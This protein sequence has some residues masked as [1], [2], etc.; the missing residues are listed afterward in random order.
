MKKTLVLWLFLSS[1]VVFA[2]CVD[3]D[4]VGDGWGMDGTKKCR[5]RRHRVQKTVPKNLQIISVDVLD[6]SAG[7]A[8]IE[9][10]FSEPA[11]VMFKY[12]KTRDLERSGSYRGFMLLETYEQSL[13][14]LDPD[15]EYFYKLVVSDRYRKNKVESN[16][17]S[18]KTLP[19]LISSTTTIS[20]TTTTSSS[21]TTTSTTT[22]LVS[23][24]LQLE[25]P[26]SNYVLRDPK[27]LTVYFSDQD[28]TGERIYDGWI[29]G[30]DTKSEIGNRA[31][32]VTVSDVKNYVSGN[33]GTF[34]FELRTLD[35]RNGKLPSFSNP[36]RITNNTESYGK[37]HYYSTM[38]AFNADSSKIAL[39][40]G[41]EGQ[42]LGD[43]QVLVDLDGRELGVLPFNRNVRWSRTDPDIV[44]G[45]RNLKGERHTGDHDLIRHNIATGDIKVI[46]KSSDFFM[47]GPKSSI[48]YDEK[49]I[50]IRTRAGD[51]KLRSLNL[52]TGAELGSKPDNLPDNQVV[53]ITPSGK[54][55]LVVEVDGNSN[56][57]Y[58]YNRDFTNRTFLTSNQ[59]HADVGL[60]HTGTRDILVVLGN[61]EIIDI[62]SG[63]I[64]KPDNNG[65]PIYGHVSGYGMPGQFLISGKFNGDRMLF[66]INTADGVDAIKKRIKWGDLRDPNP[67]SFR[68][69]QKPNLSP[70]GLRAIFT[71]DNGTS[72][73]DE[74]IIQKSYVE[75]TPQGS[76]QIKYE[77]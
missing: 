26:P 35:R 41:P 30:V 66:E 62:E 31:N 53:L 57:F 11:R 13:T 5:L 50:S 38:T 46:Y 49:F 14:N 73:H 54:Y 75:D 72:L 1:S 55:I 71:E 6:I 76:C 21:S 3:V 58:R 68:S 4:P 52:D 43:K 32:S 77:F 74:Y 45:I 16:I 36:K 27:N 64:I 60:D 7:S 34:T 19:D 20:T 59:N 8:R 69:M 9:A 25:C 37:R 29:N 70:D 15:T 39:Q 24:G 18:F 61:L 12:G 44:Y 40:E 47:I 17:A 28:S 51:N 22:T 65:K 33:S 10:K 56:S 42:T 48:S 2:E 23:T 63:D 67:V